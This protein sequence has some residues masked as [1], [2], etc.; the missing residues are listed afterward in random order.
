[1]A[2]KIETL[3]AP[4]KTKWYN[5]LI[6]SIIL[7]EVMRRRLGHSA[8]VSAKFLRQLECE[9]ETGLRQWSHAWTHAICRYA[10]EC[11]RVQAHQSMQLDGRVPNP[12]IPK[13][14]SIFEGI[15]ESKEALSCLRMGISPSHVAMIEEVIAKEVAEV[16]SAPCF[17]DPGYYESRKRAEEFE[18]LRFASEAIRLG[19]QDVVN[20]KLPGLN[21]T[22][23]TCTGTHYYIDLE[24]IVIVRSSDSDLLTGSYAAIMAAV[25]NIH[26]EDGTWP[27]A[28][29]ALLD[30]G[31]MLVSFIRGND[32][33]FARE[34]F[35]YA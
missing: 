23:S 24:G 35:A 34:W 33:E 18:L 31:E 5:S 15:C 17:S 20:A 1:M 10:A 7:F 27:F 13:L 8:T 26:R 3:K 16:R 25:G 4:T 28:D 2:T 12:S 9:L 14:L 11:I 22:Y 6:R 30:N 32:P 21:L 19:Y 29:D